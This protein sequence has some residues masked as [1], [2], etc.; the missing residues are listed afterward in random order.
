[1]SICFRILTFSNA[2]FK[3]VNNLHFKGW[4]SSR[5][6]IHFGKL[7]LIWLIGNS[8]K[9][10]ENILFISSRV[11]SEQLIQITVVSY[12]TSRLL[13]NSFVYSELGFSEFNT[14]TKGLFKDFNSFTTR[15]SALT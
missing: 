11:N 15:S 7:I 14:I 10:F 6:S 4:L 5:I 9:T 8:Y 3:S 13:A 2:D 1:M 12:F